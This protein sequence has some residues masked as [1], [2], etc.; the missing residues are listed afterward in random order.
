MIL[1]KAET[2]SIF[3]HLF[4]LVDHY[5]TSRYKGQNYCAPFVM[6]GYFRNHRMMIKYFISAD[7]SQKTR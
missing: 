7:I 2:I 1:I 3:L 6:E 4:M 5:S